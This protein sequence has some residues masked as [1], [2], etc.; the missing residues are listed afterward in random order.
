MPIDP[1]G[2]KP[3]V[4]ASFGGI[5]FAGCKL[6]FRK[7]NDPSFSTILIFNGSGSDGFKSRFTRV[8]DPVELLDPT[9]KISDLVGCELNW[10]VLFIDYGETPLSQYSFEL[11]ITQGGSDLLTPTFSKVGAIDDTSVTFGNRF[12][13]Q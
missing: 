4:T 11:K 5:D 3:V 6:F 9:K 2:D 10:S 8:I 1:N 7:K 13:F 12:F